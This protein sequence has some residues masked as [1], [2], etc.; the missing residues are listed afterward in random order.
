M[1]VPFRLRPARAEDAEAMLEAHRAA[2]RGTAAAFYPPAIIDAWA[3]LPL[4]DD[5]VEALARRIENGVEEA[6]VACAI[7][8]AA[9]VGPSL[10][11]FGSFVPERRELRAVYVRPEHGRRGIGSALLVTLERR[12]RA[13]GLTGL[14]MDA[15][16]NAEAFYRRHGFTALGAGYHVLRSGH[17]MDCIHMRKALAPR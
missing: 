6:V 2:I 17:R 16:I 12:A 11:G 15:S 4:R 5:H 14:V 3:P 8:A 1:D 10:L 7:G 13:Y 9:P